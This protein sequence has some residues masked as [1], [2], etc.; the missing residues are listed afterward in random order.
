M[1][2]V[3]PFIVVQS[4]AK[5]AFVASEVIAHEIRILGEINGLEGKP[6]E[7]LAAVDGFV[8]SGGGAAAPW[9]GT[10]FS[11]HL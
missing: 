8:L 9:F 10:P 11:V 6:P 4:Q 1:G 3:V 2:Q 5:L 7:T